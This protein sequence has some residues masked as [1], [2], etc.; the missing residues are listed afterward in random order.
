MDA[1]VKAVEMSTHVTPVKPAATRES[2]RELDPHP[3]RRA[4]VPGSGAA[5]S[6]A[7]FSSSA[8]DRYQSTPLH[9]VRA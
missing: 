5:R 3:R 6:G 8:G 9:S 4:W 2:G 1:L 7:S